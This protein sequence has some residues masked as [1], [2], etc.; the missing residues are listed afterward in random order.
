MEPSTM[1]DVAVTSRCSQRPVYEIAHPTTHE[2]AT[3][4]VVL[5]FLLIERW[6]KCHSLGERTARTTHASSAPIPAPANACEGS[7]RELSWG[8]SLRQAAHGVE[9]SR[10]SGAT[11]G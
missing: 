8:E 10:R 5:P 3:T 2:A 9:A 7:T 6:S 4:S 11:V 1:K